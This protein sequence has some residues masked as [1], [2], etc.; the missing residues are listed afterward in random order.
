MENLLHINILEGED[1][2]SDIIYITGLEP[3]IWS[4]LFFII[5]PILLTH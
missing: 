1:M 2:S 5:V 4:C 3:I